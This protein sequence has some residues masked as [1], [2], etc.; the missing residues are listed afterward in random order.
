MDNFELFLTQTNINWCYYHD[1][2]RVLGTTVGMLILQ[3]FLA[4]TPN[5]MARTI[6]AVEGGGLVIFRRGTTKSLK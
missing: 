6:E 1:T 2:H 3:D 5:L 4:L